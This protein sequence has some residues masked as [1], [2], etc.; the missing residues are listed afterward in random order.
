MHAVMVKIICDPP[1]GLSHVRVC[2]LLLFR[3]LRP[4]RLTSAMTK[5]VAAMLGDKFVTSQPYDLERSFQV[6]A[7]RSMCRVGRFRINAL[8]G[9]AF[10]HGTCNN[11]M[12][13]VTCMELAYLID[14]LILH[15]LPTVLCAQAFLL[16][17]KRL[18]LLARGLHSV[19]VQLQACEMASTLA[20]IHICA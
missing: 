18:P 3:A 13:Y 15:V 5:F 1:L 2:R 4:D 10:W 7:S 9:S 8:Y 20:C 19:R 12:A 16:P 17:S 6:R 14:V 11:Y